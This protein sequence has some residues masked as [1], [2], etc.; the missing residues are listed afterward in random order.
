[1]LEITKACRACGGTNRGEVIAF[2]ELPLV[3]ALL[4][5]AQLDNGGEARYPLTLLF[6][7]DCSL[8]QIR[9]NV[10]P[11]ILFGR[12]YP[13]YSSISE[14]WVRHCRASAH[15]LVDTRGLDGDSLALEIACNDGYMLKSFLA[16]GV[17]V[18]GIDPAPGPAAAA[19]AAGIEVIEGFFTGEL[20][21]ELRDAGRCADVVLAN[22]VLAHVP[23]LPGFVAGIRA[24]LADDGVAVIEVPYVADL[25]DRCAFDTIYHEHHCYFSVTALHRLFGDHGLFL[26]GVRRL[27]THGGS[28]RLFVEKRSGADDEVQAMLAEERDRGIDRVDCYRDFAARIQDIQRAL[29][30]LLAGL[31]AQGKHIAAYAAAAKGAMLLNSS[32]VGL[33]HVDY[34]VDLNRNKQGRFMPGVHLPILPPARL[35]EDPPDYV[36]LLAWNLRDEIIGQQAEYTARGGRFIVPIPRPEVV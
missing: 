11:D 15:E 35:L 18:I 14:G 27:P 26:N 33:D 23:D 16:R 22:N 36:L 4:T 25:I 24:V 12:D 6:C 7:T 5:R 1:M 17:P 20:A 29:V 2:G 31:K 8:S 30:E 19:R 28:L 21:A 13:Y 3:D 32:G 9:E 34:V 10:A